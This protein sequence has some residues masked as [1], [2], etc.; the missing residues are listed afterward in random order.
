MVLL[1]IQ[2]IDIYRAHR[3]TR[4]VGTSNGAFVVA[5]GAI[6]GFGAAFLRVSQGAIMTTYVP[7]AQKGRAIAVFWIIF[8]LGGGV[9]HSPASDLTT[10]TSARLSRT[11]PTLRFSSSWLLGGL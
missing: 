3:L 5:S 4:D 11:P 7:E 10:A 8:N 6:L 9:D 2:G 1:Y